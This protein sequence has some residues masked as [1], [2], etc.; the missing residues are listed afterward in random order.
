MVCVC[1]TMHRKNRRIPHDAAGARGRIARIPAPAA[2]PQ[3]QESGVADGI[4]RFFLAPYKR[5]GGEVSG[6]I[7]F[8][9]PAEV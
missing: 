2:S 4:V 6:G 9:T 5:R 8:S 7:N 3:A 1:A